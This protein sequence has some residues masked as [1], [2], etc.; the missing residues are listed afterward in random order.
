MDEEKK[1]QGDQQEQPQGEEG[2]SQ[3]AFTDEVLDSLKSVIA[4]EV[5]RALAEAK[6]TKSDGD[7]SD[8]AESK[9]DKGDESAS[10]DTAD[11]NELISQMAEMKQALDGYQKLIERYVKEART[12]VPPS[13]AALLDKLPLQEQFEYLSSADGRR[14]QIPKTPDGKR[15]DDAERRK[16]AINV[17]RFW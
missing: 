16:K 17:R 6:A 13:I 8:G 15:V 11:A 7:E 12:R 14:E 9:G 3:L 4:E 5:Q 2:R 1:T 10:A